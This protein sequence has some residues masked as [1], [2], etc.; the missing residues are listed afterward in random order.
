M[1]LKFKYIL[2]IITISLG[3]S[4]PVFAQHHI[5]SYEFKWALFHPFAAIKIKRQ[6]PKAMLVYAEIRDARLLDTLANGG[7]LDAFRHSYTM[8]YLARKSKVKKLR[9]LGIAHEKGNK[10]QFIK[11]QLEDGERPDSLACEMD[12]RNNELGFSIGRDHRL[13]NDTELKQLVLIAISEGKAWYLK[14]NERFA[15]VNCAHEALEM[16]LYNRKW[17]VPKCLVKTNE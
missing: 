8:A 4:T 5:S 17:F 3:V 11:E 14:R 7:K 15:Y 13:A 16:S 1:L 2:V 6:L 9:K 12:L 10:R